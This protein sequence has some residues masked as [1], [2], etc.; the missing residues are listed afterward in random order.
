MS[1][2]RCREEVSAEEYVYWVAYD[3]IEPIGPER[4]DLYMAQLCAC[5][6]NTAPRRRGGKVWAAKDYLIKW[7]GTQ[8]S[9]VEMQSSLRMS[10]EKQGIN[11]IEAK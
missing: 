5:V 7:A 2:A 3:S 9:V 1:V 10:L 11:F 6:S 4:Q 8:Q